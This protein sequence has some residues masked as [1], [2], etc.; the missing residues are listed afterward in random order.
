MVIAGAGLGGLAAAIHLRRAGLSVVC[1]EPEPFPHAKVGESFDWSAPRLLQSLGL[2]TK[3]LVD[4]GMA[5]YK[6][7]IRVETLGR[8]PWDAQPAPWFAR[9]PLEF[10][11]V[12]VNVDRVQ[13]DQRLRE[14]AVEA[15]VT[16]V[17]DSVSELRTEGE[18]VVA[19]RT[20]SGS[21]L[22]ASWFI[23]ASGQA[24]LFARQFGITK[25]DYGRKK[26]CLWTYFTTP[27]Y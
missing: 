5:I 10:E 20:A 23:D 26:V 11:T 8:S 15:A 4:E 21:V 27:P 18:R 22:E 12:T 14:L 17:Q 24:R 25:K 9:K 6:R 1:I 16:F 13:F 19:C 7:G 2:S 3:Q